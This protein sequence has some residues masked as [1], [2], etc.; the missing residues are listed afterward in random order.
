MPCVDA[1]FRV[2]FA[3]MNSGQL[4]SLGLVGRVV[5]VYASSNADE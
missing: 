1:Y 4:S 5:A 3:L 2:D